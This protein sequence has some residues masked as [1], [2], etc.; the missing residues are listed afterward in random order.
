M[1]ASATPKKISLVWKGSTLD[2]YPLQ[3][4]Q[5]GLNKIMSQLPKQP[6][7]KNFIKK[8]YQGNLKNAVVR[9]LAQ[10]AG[11][12]LFA[13]YVAH[14]NFSRK[15]RVFTSP[16]IAGIKYQILTLPLSKVESA[17]VDIQPIAKNETEE[18]SSPAQCGYLL[19]I[20]R[21]LLK[22]DPNTPIGD[23]I[24]TIYSTHSKDNI[25]RIRFAQAQVTAKQRETPINNHYKPDIS[26]Y[27]KLAKRQVNI[28]I[29]L[30]TPD[31]IKSSER[32]E[33]SLIESDSNAVGIFLIVD[34]EKG[35]INHDRSRIYQPEDLKDP[36][37]KAIVK[38][39]IG[40]SYKIAEFGLGEI[41]VSNIGA[42]YQRKLKRR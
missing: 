34:P 31:G 33:E 37:L 41:E 30:N 6:Q 12:A 4:T 18:E 8:N 24:K 35:S 1:F 26:F 42:G 9:S 2:K 10:L 28:K 3:L 38:D 16:D 15:L 21:K 19:E 7:L 14:P 23:A 39:A 27:H 32:H 40:D 5:S 20:L 13:G 29:D 22:I 11:D 36:N 17:I 25:E